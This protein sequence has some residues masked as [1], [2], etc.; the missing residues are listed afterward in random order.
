MTQTV[1]IWL[2][3]VVGALAA[4]GGAATATVLWWWATPGR[5]MARWL[6]PMREVL[7]Q[8][9]AEQAFEQ[10]QRSQKDKLWL[11]KQ[12]ALWRE[13]DE[14]R[15]AQQVTGLLTEMRA[16]VRPVEA[17]RIGSDEVDAARLR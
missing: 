8:G 4:L 10:R 15:H 13:S 7:E 16:L 2:L 14:Q 6:A 3:L 17:V 12:Q 1:E 5:L 11:R 9:F